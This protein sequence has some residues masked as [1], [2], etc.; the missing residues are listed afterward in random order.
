VDRRVQQ[1]ANQS[2]IKPY[3]GIFT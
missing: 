3:L 2:S 1:S